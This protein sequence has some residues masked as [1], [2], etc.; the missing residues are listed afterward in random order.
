LLNECTIGI[1]D[2]YTGIM[3]SS[4]LCFSRL[5]IDALSIRKR[6]IDIISMVP[7]VGWLTGWLT[8]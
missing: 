6:Q 2:Y 1:K 4:F 7:A 8:G 3:T 5:M